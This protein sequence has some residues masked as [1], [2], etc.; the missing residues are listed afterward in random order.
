[1]NTPFAAKNH[2]YSNPFV[3]VLDF[4][5]N[6]GCQK[7]RVMIQVM[8]IKKDRRRSLTADDPV[9]KREA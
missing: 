2:Q 8:K 3:S 7:I 9:G 1:M 6:S 5:M 4:R